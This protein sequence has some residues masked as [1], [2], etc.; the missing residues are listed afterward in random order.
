MDGDDDDQQLAPR[1]T[2]FG[3]SMNAFFRRS[4]KWYALA[5][6]LPI[7]GISLF[8]VISVVLKLASAMFRP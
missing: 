2:S 1:E 5:N 3:T 4:R 7:V 8:A 6:I